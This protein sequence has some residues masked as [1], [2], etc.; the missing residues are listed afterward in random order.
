MR[1]PKQDNLESV[2]DILEGSHE[3]ILVNGFNPD[4]DKSTAP[5]DIWFNS[6]VWDP[7]EQAITHELTSS[8]AADT[9][10]VTSQGT[11]SGG[12]AKTLIDDS[13]DFISDG[14]FIG[15][16]VLNDKRS[17]FSV[18]I[19][20]SQSILIIG[21]I[22]GSA[23]ISDGEDYRIVQ[24]N[25]TGASVVFIDYLDGEHNRRSY[26]KVLN[27]QNVVNCDDILRVNDFYI[28]GAFS[29]ETNN[30]GLI[31][32]NNQQGGRI[33]DQ[34]P[35]NLGSR[36][37]CVF[38]VPSN[39]T[40]YIVSF[41]ASIVEQTATGATLDLKLTRFGSSGG[42]GSNIVKLLDISSTGTNYGNKEFKP[43]L[44]VPQFTDIII[45]VE[46]VTTNNA[47]VSASLSILLVKNG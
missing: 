9:G 13:A 34:I 33:T 29:K 45:R 23:F 36:S 19:Q 46:S 26:F 15:D 4:T 21:D 6:G 27:G 44:P 38:T 11:A 1:Y 16:V 5:E 31:N 39:Y 8:S 22:D 10:I 12:G 18:V 7:P 40:A 30:V 37:T 2:I 24:S 35:P 28:C 14:V 20:V 25:S 42:N 3:R 47:S 32:L 41:N 43:A 17:I